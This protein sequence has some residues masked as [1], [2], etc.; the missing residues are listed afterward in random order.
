MTDEELK[1]ALDGLHA[2]DS[3]CTDSGIKDELLRER[4]KAEVAKD[5]G[6]FGGFGKRIS[7]LARELYLSDE[8]IEQGHTL[9]SVVEFARWLDD[10]MR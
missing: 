6:Q 7:R 1:D 8:A 5:L 10:L 2:Y 4:V 9:E 3:G